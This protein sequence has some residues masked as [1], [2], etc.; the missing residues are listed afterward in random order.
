LQKAGTNKQNQWRAHHKEHLLAVSLANLVS[1]VQI[2]AKNTSNSI[3]K[4]NRKGTC[5]EYQPDLQQVTKP[6][7]M[8]DRVQLR[9]N[10][11]EGSRIRA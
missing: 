2:H 1:V 11:M 10:L 4:P 6:I 5:Y 8:F 9:Q 7:S 3:D